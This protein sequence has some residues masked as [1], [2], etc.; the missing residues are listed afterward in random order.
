MKLETIDMGG[1][2]NRGQVEVSALECKILDFISKK[3]VGESLEE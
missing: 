1:P 3:T 2:I